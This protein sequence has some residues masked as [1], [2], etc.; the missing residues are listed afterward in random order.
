MH[1]H[2]TCSITLLLSTAWI[3]NRKVYLKMVPI[4]IALNPHFWFYTWVLGPN[5]CIMFVLAT[6]TRKWCPFLYWSCITQASVSELWPDVLTRAQL[7]TMKLQQQK[8]SVDC[9]ALM[10]KF[11][12][13]CINQLLQSP[14]FQRLSE[15]LQWSP[16]CTSSIATQSADW[17]MVLVWK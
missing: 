15:L 11:Y 8:S 5:S 3:T 2:R 12:Y 4:P 13:T 10:S 17:H 16:Q 9:T 7:P 6:H 14:R 1:P